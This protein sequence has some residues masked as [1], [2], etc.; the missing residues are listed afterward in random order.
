[1]SQGFGVEDVIRRSVQNVV[2]DPIFVCPR[3]PLEYTVRAESN[4]PMTSSKFFLLA[5]DFRAIEKGILGCGAESNQAVTARRWLPIENVVGVERNELAATTGAQPSQRV[6]RRWSTRP[7]DVID[8]AGRNRERI[9]VNLA[10]LLAVGDQPIA[11]HDEQKIELVDRRVV[12]RQRSRPQS[13]VRGKLPQ[14]TD[15]RARRPRENGSISE[16]L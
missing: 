10:S 5:Q 4:Q 6:Y 11:E 1:M 9:D 3:K 14:L 13:V 16:R 15:A 7:P 8:T 12:S 2:P